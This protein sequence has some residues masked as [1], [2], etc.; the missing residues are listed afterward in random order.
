MLLLSHESMLLPLPGEEPRV[1]MEEMSWISSSSSSGELRGWRGVMVVVVVG[2]E[3]L[4]P[5]GG[6][7]RG[8]GLGN[9]SML[10]PGKEERKGG[11]DKKGF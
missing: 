7:E 4:S 3:V 9:R 11:G 6:E 10:G 1:R 8:G 5:C 2:V